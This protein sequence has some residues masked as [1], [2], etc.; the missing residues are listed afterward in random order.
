MTVSQNCL[1]G[2]IC[3]QIFLDICARSS[4]L[5]NVYKA[6]SKTLCLLDITKST[7]FVYTSIMNVE[8]GH[9]A[10]NGVPRTREC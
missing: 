4:F 3:E 8:W 10:Q 5:C 2:C 6:L 1:K 9:S 7:S